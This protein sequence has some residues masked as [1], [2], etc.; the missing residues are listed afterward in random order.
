MKLLWLSVLAVFASLITACNTPDK[1]KKDITVIEEAYIYGYPLIL[2]DVTKEVMTATANPTE[3]KAPIN[4]FAYLRKFP[5]PD[6]KDIVS[7]NADTLYSVA[8]LDLSKEPIVITVPEMHDRYYIYELLDS[9]TNVFSSLGTRTTGQNKGTFAIVGPNWKGTLPKDLKKVQSPTN[10]VWILGRIKTDGPSDYA[11]VNKLQD[12]FKLFPLNAFGTDY[13][14][15]RDVPIEPYIDVNTPPVKQ[16]DQMDG[17][18]FFT[19]LTALL[20]TNPP[21]AADSSMVRKL[22]SIGI[23]PG[24]V[25]DIKALST[26]QLDNLNKLIANAKEIIKNEAITTPSAINANGWKIMIKQVGDYGTNYL[27][28]AAT[29]FKGLGAN[30]AKDA[31]YPMLV[32]DANGNPLSGS[33]RYVLHFTKEQI[34]PV[35]AFWSLTLYDDKQFFVPNPIDRYTIGDRSQMQINPDGSLDIY[36]QNTSPGK[37]KESNWLPAPKGDFNL[38]LRL[39]EPKE[40][41]L[42]SQWKPPAIKKL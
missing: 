42:N 36:I 15:P 39:Y 37:T 23:V 14:P 28:R 18:T 5:T 13:K 8:W 9:W 3:T 16:V 34:P 35:K 25:F 22:A 11:A 31:V 40:E 41:V 6:F 1:E 7:P 29:A 30:L 20:K 24:K 12:E 27:L 33:N 19:N 38:V 17:I 32:T 2:M 21:L 26:E 4:Q 10:T